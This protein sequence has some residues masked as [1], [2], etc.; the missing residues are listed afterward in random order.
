MWVGEDLKTNTKRHVFKKDRI[1]CSRYAYHY[2]LNNEHDWGDL[3][4]QLMSM[5][6]FTLRMNKIFI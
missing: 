6:T 1:L 4:D 2:S 5:E 3:Y